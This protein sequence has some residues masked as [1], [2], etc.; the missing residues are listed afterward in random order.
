MRPGE[1][2][3]GHVGNLMSPLTK[4]PKFQLLSLHWEGLGSRPGIL[5][6]DLH[7]PGKLLGEQTQNKG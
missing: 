3:K 7:G 1:E 6:A 5:G 4:I 2:N